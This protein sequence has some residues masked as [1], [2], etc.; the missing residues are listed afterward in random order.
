MGLWSFFSSWILLLCV[1][2]LFSSIQCMYPLFIVQSSLVQT[3]KDQISLVQS[4]LVIILLLCVIQIF[5]SIQCMQWLF[6][7][8][9]SLVQTSVDQFQSTLVKSSQIL[10]N[11]GKSRKFFSRLFLAAYSAC[12]GSLQFSWHFWQSF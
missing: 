5:S 12:G 6:L 9:S 3:S 2:Q 10:S 4:N 8:Q 11:L 1:I 7:A